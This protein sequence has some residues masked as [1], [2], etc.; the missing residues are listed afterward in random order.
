MSNFEIAHNTNAQFKFIPAKISREVEREEIT[1]RKG[2]T[3]IFNF[4]DTERKDMK[5]NPP[6]YN[7][8]DNLDK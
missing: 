3:N 1:M 8:K 2:T 5:K 6:L 7:L 4:R